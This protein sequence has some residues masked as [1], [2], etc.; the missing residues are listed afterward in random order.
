M[1]SV[2]YSEYLSPLALSLLLAVIA[3]LVYLWLLPKPFLNVPHNPVTSIW[4]DIPELDRFMEGGKRN[5]ADYFI[6]FAAKYGP[7]SQ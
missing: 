2:R 3:Y 6:S 1:N 5:I 7:L 4:G